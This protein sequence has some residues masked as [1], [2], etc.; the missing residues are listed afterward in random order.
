MPLP[1]P[2]GA[3]CPANLINLILEKKLNLPTTENRKYFYCIHNF[4]MPIGGVFCW[5][6]PF[7]VEPK[8]VAVV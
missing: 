1:S 2:I 3:T 7:F 5:F 6:V 4:W 8:N